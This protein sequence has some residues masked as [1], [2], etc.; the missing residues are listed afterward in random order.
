[1]II[2]EN[3]IPIKKELIAKN[4]DILINTISITEGTW[5]FSE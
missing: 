2:Q 5:T 4:K 1:M 3:K